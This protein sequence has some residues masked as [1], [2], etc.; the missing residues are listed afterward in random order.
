ME[1]SDALYDADSTIYSPD[2]RLFQVEYARE[3]VK[4]G[5]T[6]I[7]LKF[8]NGVL[9]IAYTEASS[10]LVEKSSTD[11][12]SQ[13]DNTIGC[14]FTGL[15]ADAR[16]LI[17]FAREEAEIN[18]IWYDE[19]ITIKALVRTICEYKHLFTLYGGVRPF[20]DVLFVGGI[21]ITG[22]H[23]FATDPSG[24]FLE[25]KAV[26][27]GKGSNKAML[28]FD[29]NYTAD[30]TLDEAFMFGIQAIKKTLGKKLDPS[31]IEIASIK[32]NEK[33]YKFSQ[34][35]IKHKAKKYL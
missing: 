22:P 1:S 6:T 25:Y 20:G 28:Y 4:R 9:L 30:P 2:G 8:K 14:A 29:Q 23:L 11:K 15:S 17:E 31:L 24:A 7:G 21:D 12:I 3:T 13:I 18:R 33:F 5:A 32:L 26:C 27:E 35:E 19:Q 16:H 34:S 10:P